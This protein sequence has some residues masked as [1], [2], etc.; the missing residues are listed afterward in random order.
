M[1]Q[2]TGKNEMEVEDEIKN[3]EKSNGLSQIRK[4]KAWNKI[5]DTEEELNKTI[6]RL[7]K[8]NISSGDIPS[9]LNNLN[10]AK[11]AYFTRDYK[12]S[13]R[14]SGQSENKV[15]N[16]RK[17]F[18]KELEREREIEVET[19]NNQSR[20][21]VDISGV[22]V[23]FVL[24]TS[25]RDKIMSEIASRTG[26]S[27]SEIKGILKIKK[28]EPKQEVEGGIKIGGVVN[29]IKQITKIIKVTNEM[30]NLINKTNTSK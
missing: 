25:N 12:K 3:L 5:K 2:Q 4:E 11:D 23:N 14:L 22:K 18:E 30:Q 19:E 29:M 28:E 7:N 16:Y 17:Q 15:E 1:E 10:Q 27:I 24:D 8:L 6:K 13:L 9:A 21:K 20:V 26:L